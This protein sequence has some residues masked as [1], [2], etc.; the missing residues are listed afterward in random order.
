MHGT[1]SAAMATPVHEEQVLKFMISIFDPVHIW[2]KNND[3]HELSI[4]FKLFEMHSKIVEIN[5]S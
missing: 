2:L 1:Q 5:E 4:E 3:R